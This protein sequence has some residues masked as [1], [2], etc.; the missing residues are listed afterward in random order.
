MRNGKLLVLVLALLITLSGSTLAAPA[1]VQ[2]VVHGAQALIDAYREIFAD[3]TAQTGIPVEVIATTGGQKGKWEKVLTLVAGGVS[4]D[5][6]GGV[7]TEFGEFAI[8]GLLRPLDDLIRTSRVRMDALVPPFIEALQLGGKQ[9]LLPYGSSALVMFYNT[10]HL[11]TAGLAYPPREWNTRDWDYSAFVQYAKKLTIPTPDGGINQ[12]GIAGIFWDSW[13]T[14][15]YPWGG[16][17]VSDDLRTFEGTRPDTIASLQALQDLI[18][19]HQVMPN[20]GGQGNFVSHKGSM[21][22]LGTWSLAA[23][24]TSDVDWDFMPWFRVK[25]RAQAAIF[26]IGYGILST[27]KNMDESWELIRWLTWNEKGNLEYATAA[28]AIPSLRSNLPAW[29]NHWRETVGRPISADVV[30]EQAGLYGGI[31]QIRK[32]PAFWTINDIMGAAA[33]EVT[34][35][36][37][38]AQA[39]LEEVAPQIQALL[40]ET[41]P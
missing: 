38:S 30:I 7:S 29:R 8:S 26:P 21:A 34:A 32:S 15:P 9:Y 31:V 14:L 10:Q 11:D 19:E 40:E 2:Y 3:F 23:L 27:S 12:Y 6:V 18:Y 4:P 16:R 36:R 24:A 13:I 22:G 39:A 41:A 28:G 35:N 20:G 17:W 25:D 1:T 5:V 33:R 37:K